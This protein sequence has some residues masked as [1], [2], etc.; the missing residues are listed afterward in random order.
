M[1]LFGSSLQHNTHFHVLVPEG[2]FSAPSPETEGRAT[3]L[4]LPPP[5][6][7]EV[8]SL[9]CTTAQRL[10]RLLERLGRLDEDAY[11]HDALQKRPLDQ[12][13]PFRTLPGQK[14]APCNERWG[15]EAINGNCWVALAD[16]KPP[17][18][19]ALFRHG[20]K[21]Y[22]PVGGPWPG[23]PGPDRLGAY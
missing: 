20:D 13:V 2:L 9:L 10:V 14:V 11:P 4:P 17:C 21:C 12:T 7:E 19:A 23:D 22:R 18:D 3:F 1:Q 5:E 16:V 6:D 8:E 15:E